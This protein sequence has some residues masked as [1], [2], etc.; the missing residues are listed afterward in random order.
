VRVHWSPRAVEDLRE[1][2]DYVSADSPQAARRL[3]R[4]LRQATQRLSRFPLSGR[5][6]PEFP[7]TDRREVIS[8]NYRIIYGPTKD[9]VE[10]L[11]VVHGMRDLKAM[12]GE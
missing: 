10:I 11:V 9:G 7:E 5:I 3:V 1:I 2:S 6:V 8:G 4:Q 12:S